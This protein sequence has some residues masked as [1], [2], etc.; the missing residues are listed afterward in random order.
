MGGMIP[1]TAALGSSELSLAMISNWSGLAFAFAQTSSAFF[2][3]L[4]E[5][6]RAF[7]FGPYSDSIA[8]CARSSVTYFLTLSAAKLT[9]PREQLAK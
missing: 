6:K 3:V 5:I 4:T 8:F 1:I 7:T 9:Q 2:C